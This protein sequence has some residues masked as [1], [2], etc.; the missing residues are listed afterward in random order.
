[1]FV[2]AFTTGFLPRDATASQQ[3]EMDDTANQRAAE[4]ARKAGPRALLKY[5]GLIPR[6]APDPPKL[7]RRGL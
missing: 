1:V 3:A 5:F 2:I 6:D 4:T 7:K